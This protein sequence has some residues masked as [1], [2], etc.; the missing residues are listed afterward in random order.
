MKW[1][2]CIGLWI[3]LQ[4]NSFRLDENFM[5]LLREDIVPDAVTCQDDMTILNLA[6]IELIINSSLW[7]R[8]FHFLIRVPMDKVG[9][10]LI[11]M[12]E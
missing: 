8:E 3:L 11:G 12:I 6:E 1:Y 4:F 10:D 5:Y 7:F 2:L 9:A